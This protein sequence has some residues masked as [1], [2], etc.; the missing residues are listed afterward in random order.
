MPDRAITA[1]GSYTQPDYLFREGK[2]AIV[3]DPLQA[4]RTRTREALADVGRT[5]Q[6]DQQDE[7]RQVWRDAAARDIAKLEKT[8]LAR[9]KREMDVNATIFGVKHRHNTMRHGISIA[10]ADSQ[11]A[12][13]RRHA[14]NLPV[15][16]R[17]A[18]Y[19]EVCRADDVVAVRALELGSPSLALLGLDRDAALAEGAELQAA[20]ISAKHYAEWQES[21]DVYQSVV[22]DI[23]ATKAALGLSEPVVTTA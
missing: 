14:L 8:E 15:A 17:A 7:P 18:F 1:S 19:H 21:R 3:V 9:L 20:A 13:I 5:Y 4:I 10:Q 23:A 11:G 16:A 2:R 22:G 12:E 6:Q